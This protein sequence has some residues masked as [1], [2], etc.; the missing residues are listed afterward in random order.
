MKWTPKIGDMVQEFFMN[1]KEIFDL[2]GEK[3]IVTGA[4]QGLGEQMALG[5]AEAGVDVAVV[6][7]NTNR[8]DRVVESIRN[9][10][11]EAISI[12]ADVTKVSDVEDMVKMVKERFGK[13]DILINN[14]GI[15]NNLPAEEIS[16]EEWDRIIEVNL[17]GVFLCAQVVGR[18]MIKQKKGNIIN[19]SSMS[20]LIVNRP[21]PQIHYNT[22]KAGVI[23]ITKSLAGEWAK[24]N[25]RVNA[26]APG[27]MRTP[28]VDKVFPKYGKDWASLTPM[29]RIGDP[30]EIKGP[31]LFLA[32]KAS[33]FFTG[34]VLVMDGGYTLW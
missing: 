26:I 25:I 14:A 31:V 34:S 10:G 24:Y 3:A 6:D 12:K 19:I 17:S 7:I 20:G 21:Q 33:S 11:R 22:S 4:A 9:L 18:E 32:S 1:V 5:L 29:G 13:I 23:M 15:V 27:Y 28:L 30:S 8:A 16:K 2:T